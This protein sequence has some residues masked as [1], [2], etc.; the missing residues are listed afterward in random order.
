MVLDV[1]ATDKAGKPIQG[2]T[3]D[4]F[5]VYEDKVPQRIRSFEGAAAHALPES[6]VE[7]GAAAVFD[8][9]KP[10]SFGT[11]PVTVLV[12]DQLNTHFADSSF[13][14]RELHDFLQK[15]PAVLAQPT[16][17]VTLYQT[18]FKELYRFTRDRDALL[19]ALTQ[20][21]VKY[22]WTLEENGKAEHGPIERLQLSL[23]ALEEIAQSY[24][25][26]RGRKNLVWVGNGF[27]SV[28]PD[29]LSGRD[30]GEVQATLE[31]VT[32]VLLNTRVTLYAVDPTSTLPGMTEITTVTQQQFVT[33]GG[34]ALGEGSLDT[35][36]AGDDFD[37]LGIVSGGGVV[38]GRN[39][40]AA[41]I[42]AAV[43]TGAVYYTLSYSP[44][45]SNTAAASYRRIHVECLRPGCVATTRQ[46]YF[47]AAAA[48]EAAKTS[49]TNDLSAA[50]ESAMPLHALHV[51]VESGSALA[52]QEERFAISVSAP[53][54]TWSPEED[55][56]S[57]ASVYIMAV[58]L[59]RNGK[60]LEHE[61]SAEH[62]DAKPGVNL[63]DESKTA[64][65]AMMANPALK[66]TTLRFVVRD[67][68][69]GRMGTVDMPVTKK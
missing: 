38:R 55:G 37:K 48:A 16:T 11:S 56:S 27:P 46:G 45:S 7:H 13:A 33:A 12:L 9:E 21:P 6:A 68:T 58:S 26:V 18:R 1:S 41:Q 61:V 10:A 65:F 42:A 53:G 34:G 4:D 63:R 23:N 64:V 54:L 5:K 62:A 51:T 50:A 3:T 40:I 57:R 35:F 52:G 2:L 47:P 30:Y 22:A 29:T 59:D 20:V 39:D 24:A 32:D 44:T 31:H 60:M 25:G 43:N 28:D 49:V 66:A 36:G 17:L 67:M 19:R 14:R 69:S 8:L 15:Q